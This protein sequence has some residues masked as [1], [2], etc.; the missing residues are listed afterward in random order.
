MLKQGIYKILYNYALTS[1]D[2]PESVEYIGTEAFSD[3][4][5][6]NDNL[7]ASLILKYDAGL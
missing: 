5:K 1:V 2:I 4:K 6:L 3:C 7:D